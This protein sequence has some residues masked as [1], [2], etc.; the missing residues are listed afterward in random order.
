MA[1]IVA[2]NFHDVTVRITYTDKKCNHFRRKWWQNY[3]TNNLIKSEKINLNNVSR[4][5][6]VSHALTSD[7]IVTRGPRGL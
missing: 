5:I 6:V 7:Q 2:K 3:V 1:F 4:N